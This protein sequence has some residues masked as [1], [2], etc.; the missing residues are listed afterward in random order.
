M[1]GV[2]IFLRFLALLIEKSKT[3]LSSLQENF[4]HTGGW[5]L[6][7]AYI[8]LYWLKEKSFRKYRWIRKMANA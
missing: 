7:H 4:S 1:K 5:G 2:I 8:G 6:Y 3:V